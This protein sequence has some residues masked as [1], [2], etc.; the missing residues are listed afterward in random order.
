[1]KSIRP[2]IKFSALLLLAL[3][4]HVLAHSLVLPRFGLTSVQQQAAY[5]AS[6]ADSDSEEQEHQGDFKPP[7]HSFID[8]SNFFSANCLLPVYD[9]EVSRLLSYE[10]YQALPTVY[11]EIHVPPDCLA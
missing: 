10:P 7:K 8:Y 4:L 2:T 3:T 9:P 11:L 5:S 6:L 1:M